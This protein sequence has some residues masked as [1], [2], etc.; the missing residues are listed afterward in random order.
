MS[1][2]FMREFPNE[3]IRKSLASKTFEPCSGLGQPAANPELLCAVH[4]LIPLTIPVTYSKHTKNTMQTKVSSDSRCPSWPA[5]PAV[6]IRPKQK[7]YWL[8]TGETFGAPSPLLGQ[9]RESGHQ[10]LPGKLPPS[11]LF[12]VCLISIGLSDNST[13]V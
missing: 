11:R 7:E 12:W 5:R 13:F 4:T 9:V 3:F 1:K 10:V 6:K 8:G 2:E